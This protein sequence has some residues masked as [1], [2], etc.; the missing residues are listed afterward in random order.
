MQRCP[1]RRKESGACAGPQ[2]E[3]PASAEKSRRSA[4]R[5]P[6]GRAYG[7][8]QNRGD[9]PT[10]RARVAN[11]CADK[12][13]AIDETERRLPDSAIAQAA[14]CANDRESFR[15]AVERER[16]TVEA[17]A[18]AW[19]RDEG[20]LRSRSAPRLDACD[21]RRMSLRARRVGPTG[22]P[23]GAAFAKGNA[24]PGE[25]ETARAGTATDRRPAAR[26]CARIVARD[27]AAPNSPRSGRYSRAARTGGTGRARA[28][29]SK[30][31]QRC[32]L[33]PRRRPSPRGGKVRAGA[34]LSRRRARNAGLRLSWR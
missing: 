1:G 26:P 6:V 33:W 29:R 34:R 31:A 17:F 27:D 16:S 12:K 3:A 8:A 22:D 25:P 11:A 4:L 20:G 18:S 24:R 13:R 2:K 30:R 5:I 19:P 10:R 21:A 23:T 28:G 7:R 32:R 9:E 14:R 15:S